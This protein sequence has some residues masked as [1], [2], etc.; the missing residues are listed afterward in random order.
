MTDIAAQKADA[1]KQAFATR[2]SAHQQGGD[3]VACQNLHD[4]LATLGDYQ[5]IAA[6]MP[7]RTEISPL[8]VMTRLASDGKTIALPVVVG[9][10]QPLIFRVWTPDCDMETGAFGAMI[11]QQG[12]EVAPDVVIT[13]LLAFDKHGYRLGYGGG[14]YDRSF[15]QLRRQKSVIGIGFAY[16]AQQVATVPTEPTDHRLDALVTERGVLEF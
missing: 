12:S 9:A 13:P 10:G 16:A 8:A 6:Y 11:P 2:K 5:I 14:F 3:D 4:Y 7:I 1:R 15:Q